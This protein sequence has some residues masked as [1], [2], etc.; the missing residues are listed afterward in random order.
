MEEET[1]FEPSPMA[2]LAALIDRGVQPGDD[3]T[4]IVPEIIAQMPGAPSGGAE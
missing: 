2:I 3:T 4:E 1:P